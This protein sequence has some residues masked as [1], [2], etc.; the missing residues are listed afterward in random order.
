M[1]RS[2]VVSAGQA[3]HNNKHRNFL[4]IVFLLIGVIILL[5]GIFLL[6][7]IYRTLKSG[8]RIFL[9]KKKSNEF[10]LF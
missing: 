5:A 4:R 2:S 8:M 6:T 10:E 7:I 3:H 9:N 1:N